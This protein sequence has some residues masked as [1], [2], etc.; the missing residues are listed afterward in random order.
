MT[1]PKLEDIDL[2]AVGFDV[3]SFFKGDP[4]EQFLVFE[5][6]LQDRAGQRSKLPWLSLAPDLAAQ[7]AEILQTSVKARTP[8]PPDQTGLH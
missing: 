6:V 8:A 4:P 5:L 3:R 2:E 7:L 1:G